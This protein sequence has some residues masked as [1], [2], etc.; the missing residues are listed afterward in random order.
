LTLPPGRTYATVRRVWDGNTILLEG[1]NSVRYIG[2]NTPGAG[3]FNRPL[4]PFGREAAERNI[5]LVEGKQVELEVDV[6]DVDPGGMMLRY[7]WVDGVLVNEVL[8]R[9]G[10]ARLAPMGR[11]THYASLLTAAETY[12]RFTPLNMWTLITFTPTITMTPTITDTPAP[13][14]TPTITDTP[15]PT[16]TPFFLP[17]ILRFPTPLQRVLQPP[18]VTPTRTAIFL[19]P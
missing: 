12:A 3:M 2:V 17:T 13:T 9:E 8:L 7:V 14:R 10:L 19:G 1:G 16:S 6:T 15:A 11:N 4:D 5:E 18:A